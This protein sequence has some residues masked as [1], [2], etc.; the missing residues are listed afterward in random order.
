MKSVA[1][2]FLALLL[3]SLIFSQSKSAYAQL[4][5]RK[6][7]TSTSM[8]KQ[9]RDMLPN[10]LGKSL[11]SDIVHSVI[12]SVVPYTIANTTTA[13]FGFHL[14]GN[15][16]AVL[17]GEWDMNAIF[18]TFGVSIPADPA[19]RIFTESGKRLNY[20]AWTA[21]EIAEELTKIA[22][23][24]VLTKAQQAKVLLIYLHS[25]FAVQDFIL[26]KAACENTVLFED[27]KPGY[28]LR[29]S[30]LEAF[31]EGSRMLKAL[32]D[33]KDATF[34][35]IWGEDAEFID[36]LISAIREQVAAVKGRHNSNLFSRIVSLHMK[37]FE[38]WITYFISNQ[39]GLRVHVPQNREFITN[40]TMETFQTLLALSDALGHERDVRP[41]KLP[42][43]ELRGFQANKPRSEH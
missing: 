3:A 31:L 21:D 39:K 28:M 42:F 32:I 43:D 18:Q 40:A 9:L 11:K 5:L 41:L 12:A 2:I 34:A 19:L 27:G 16:A 30:S 22:S 1:R 35:K 20:L 37:R 13:L 25:I 15:D 6:E 8:G 29:S 33:S 26:S 23:D 14:L 17:E 7:L 36:S 24:D 4:V 38:D 10:A